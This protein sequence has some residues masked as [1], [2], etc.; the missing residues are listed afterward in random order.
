MA[1]L[2]Y[3]ALVVSGF[4]GGLILALL[5]PLIAYLAIMAVFYGMLANSCLRF[6]TILK[7]NTV[8]NVIVMVQNPPPAYDG[9]PGPGG[10]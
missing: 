7:M 10:V 8:S 4:F 1:Y 5:G 9:K 3:V 6:R 2:I